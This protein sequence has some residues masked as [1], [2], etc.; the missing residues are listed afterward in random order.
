MAIDRFELQEILDPDHELQETLWLNLRVAAQQRLGGSPFG[1]TT[2]HAIIVRENETMI[3]G[4][5]GL[6]YFQGMNLQCLWV[7]DSHRRLGIGEAL[8]GRI[9]EMA[10]GLRC[11]VIFGHTFGF[12]AREFYLRL[13]Y[14][15]FGVLPEYPP[16]HGC[17]FLKKAL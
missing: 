11:N 7:Q 4:L 6:A 2:S 13:G 1:E 10:R 16:G 12:Q 15:E 3:A 17:Y 9:E 14:T 5:L 8:V